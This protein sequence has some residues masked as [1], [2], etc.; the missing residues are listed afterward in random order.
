MKNRSVAFAIWGVSIGIFGISLSFI[1]ISYQ[2][3]QNSTNFGPYPVMGVLIAAI[4]VVVSL[5]AA[6][7]SGD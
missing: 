5:L 2:L 3:A 6:L 1:G 7:T 4:G